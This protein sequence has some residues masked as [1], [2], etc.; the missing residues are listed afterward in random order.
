MGLFRDII[1]SFNGGELSPRMAARSDMAVY[2]I[3][4]ETC[5][6]FVPT[7]EGP[8]VKRP[9][10]EYI[11]PAAETTTWLGRFRFNLTQDYVI[12]WLEHK[13]RFF[14]NGGRIE[15]APG[16][17]YEVTTPYAAVDAPLLSFQQSFDRLYLAHGSYPTSA[18]SRTGAATFTYA[19]LAMDKGPFIDANSDEGII[20]SVSAATGTGISV[21]ASSPIF[22]AGQ[23]GSLFRID[24]EDFS[25]VRAWEAGRAGITVGLQVRSDGKIYEAATAGNTGS[26]QPIHTRGTESD[27]MEAGVPG[28]TD[29]YGVK[30]TY[31]SDSFGLVR[32]TA[33]GGGGTTAT[34]DVLRRLPDSL[35]TVPSWHWAKGAFSV[36]E[37]WPS[38]V[39]IWGGRMMLVKDFDLHGSV[40]GDYGGGSVNFS[41][42]TDSGT[43]TADM[44]FRRT[45][46]AEDPPLWMLGDRRAL[47][48]G[49]ASREISVSAVNTSAAVSGDNISADPQ[50]FFGSEQVYPVQIASSAIFVQ[51]GGRK[52]REAGYDFARDRYIATNMTVWCRH[53]TQSGVI[54]FAFQKEPEELLFCVRKDGTLA[55]HPHAPEQ[56]IKGFARIVLGG[57]G[58]V[59]SA[60]SISDQDG[61]NDE[62]WALIDRSGVKSIERMAKWREDGDPLSDAFYVD[63]GLT[64]MAAP[65][66]TH[67][68]GAA[69]LA[70]KAV[71]ILAGG[72]VV[73]GVVVNDDGSFDLPAG[74]APATAYR[75]TVGLP[76]TATCVTLKPE[77]KDARGTLQ[78]I[79]QKLL[80]LTLRVLE[81]SGIRVGAKGG[82]MEN[83]F[84][85]M[86]SSPMDAPPPLFTGDS[87]K[88]AVGSWDRNGQA[89]FVSDAP[90]PATVIAAMPKLEWE[91]EK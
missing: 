20:V 52:L 37:G 6:N 88:P 13:A 64:V 27:G 21:T 16:T 81:T 5:E 14:T 45:L 42:T 12:E 23:I 4:L 9:G 76:Y 85:R 48:L 44:A 28:G 24:A 19:P 2:Q 79:R 43:V 63:G 30:W 56:E 46:D 18:L 40:V 32:I 58:K 68:T 17:P 10:F 15:T 74:S 72:A 31:I 83:L 49:T 55:V 80:R 78:G 66:Q 35:I 25:N 89:V 1:N 82:Q 60:V 57:G 22:V 90:L 39:T 77:L 36:A 41:T 3:G 29:S 8:I 84:D 75:L 87:G 61:V 86:L 53:I 71:A 11:C 59:L 69:H 33:I 50:S 91:E 62:L 51:R 26:V 67:F 54:Q 70:G 65:G 7:V 38:L 73:P 34:A 47:I